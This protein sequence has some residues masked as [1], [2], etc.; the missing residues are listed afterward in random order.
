MF[1][2]VCEVI[3]N[4]EWVTLEHS[5]FS[6]PIRFTKP[7]AHGETNSTTGCISP[8]LFFDD[9]IALSAIYDNLRSLSVSRVDQF[10]INLHSTTFHSLV[11]YADLVN[12]QP[13]TF[14]FLNNETTSHLY[15]F[16]YSNQTFLES[17]QAAFLACILEKAPYSSTIYLTNVVRLEKTSLFPNKDL[18]TQ[19][20]DYQRKDYSSTRIIFQEAHRDAE[21]LGIRSQCFCSNCPDTSDC[22]SL[23]NYEHTDVE[24]IELGNSTEV[25]RSAGSVNG[26]A[27]YQEQIT[28]CLEGLSESVAE[29]PELCR[30]NLR[31]QGLFCYAAQMNF[32]HTKLND[33]IFYAPRQLSFAHFVDGCHF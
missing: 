3:E 10:V 6:L 21:S 1:K 18:I 32:F 17:V 22:F 14:D 20:L 23:T 15:S 19:L 26:T 5:D 13:W 29:D 33:A 7:P 9:A 2:L 16:V 8:L 11:D 25:A 4:V 30:I 28:S 31:K 24:H 27:F 12:Y